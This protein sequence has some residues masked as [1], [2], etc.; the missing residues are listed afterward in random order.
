MAGDWIPMR[1]DLDTDPAVIAVASALGLDEYGVVG[2]L[3]RLWVWANQ[4][5][6][7]GHARGVTS[8]W[9]DRFLCAQG[10]TEAL[11]KCGWIRVTDD[12]ICIPKFDDWNSSGAKKRLIAAKRQRK[13]RTAPV[14]KMSRSQ[15]DKSVTREEKR[16]EE[17]KESTSYEVDSSEPG[18]PA[19]EQL[20]T[21]D[22]I[23]VLT[24]Q[25]VGK[26]AKPWPLTQTQIDDWRTAFPA[27][28]V[29]GECRKALAWIAANPQKR[30]TYRG[31]PNFL[32]SWLDR[33]QNRGGSSPPNLNTQPATKARPPTETMAER[34]RRQQAEMR[35]RMSSQSNPEEA[36]S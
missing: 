34:V 31:V 10:F 20:A 36:A 32:F 2:R 12:G 6:T 23:P 7:D 29:L 19:S 4:H 5:T 35:D 24:Y 17:N 26:D 22:E 9:L 15:R 1:L 14:T 16:R 3:H 11:Q 27:V 18:K 33:A 21:A 13:K 25:T 8:V 28:D 30:K